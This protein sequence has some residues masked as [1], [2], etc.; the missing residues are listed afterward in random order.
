MHESFLGHIR[1]NVCQGNQQY[2]VYL[3]GWMARLV[4]KPNQTGEVAIVLR[5]GKGVGKSFFA[6]HFGKLF[7]R[8]YLEVSNSS[9]LV[10][11]FNAHLRDTVLL[12]AD[13]AFYANDKNTCRFKTL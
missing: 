1:S 12:F 3:L 10:G 4:Q 9:H 2:Y 11:N 5:G 8:H 6:K 13:E 7:G